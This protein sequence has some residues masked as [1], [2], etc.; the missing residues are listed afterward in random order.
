[1]KYKKVSRI[2]EL[3]DWYS[4]DKKTIIGVVSV[5]VVFLI[6]ILFIVGNPFENRDEKL[7]ELRGHAYGK[8]L[9]IKDTE[10]I[11]QGHTGS[12][13]SSVGFT[14]EY[15]FDV[16][17]DVYYGS[18]YF[19]NNITNDKRKNRLE[20]TKNIEIKYQL[21]DPSISMIVFEE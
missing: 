15:S 19:V 21:G 10:Y 7:F 1:M 11:H 16:K 13:M 3:I 12:S 17:G 20:K 9:S 14:V 6:V 4:P 8:V 2:R 18:E 5:S